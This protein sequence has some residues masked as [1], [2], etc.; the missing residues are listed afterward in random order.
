MHHENVYLEKKKYMHNS[1]EIGEHL[2]RVLRR[3]GLLQVLKKTVVYSGA[4]ELL[5]PSNVLNFCI[6]VFNMKIFFIVSFI[7]LYENIFL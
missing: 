3:A 1:V 6:G 4:V 7:K 5:F 2:L